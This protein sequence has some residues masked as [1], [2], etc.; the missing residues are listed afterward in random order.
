MLRLNLR[1]RVDVSSAPTTL[2]L[3]AAI[4]SLWLASALGYWPAAA[5][6]RALAAVPWRYAFRGGASAPRWMLYTLVHRDGGHACANLASILLAGPAAEAALG[7]GVLAAALAATALATAAV[8][9]AFFDVGL[10]GASG[11]ALV[12]LVVAAGGALAAAQRRG[13]LVLPL[14]TLALLALY[15][16]RELAGE[17]AGVSRF[18]HLAGLAAGAAVALACVA[19]ARRRGGGEHR[20]E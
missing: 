11:L 6:A 14:P 4:A 12:L 5:Q 18:A 17:S 13:E 16:C 1:V 10:I 3:S 19:R 15:L 8:N 2:L 9:A 7:S 20:E